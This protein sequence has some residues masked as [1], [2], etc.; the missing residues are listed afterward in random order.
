M[1][2]QYK[3]VVAEDETTLRDSLIKQL[4]EVWPTAKV[5]AACGD[6]ISAITAVKE[7]EPDVLFLDIRM[8][9]K[10]GLEVA[11]SVSDQTF[12]VFTT[13]YDEYAIT[14]FES[15]AID[16]LLKPIETSRLSNTVKRL[17]TRIRDQKPQNIESLIQEL[18]ATLSPD[19]ESIKWVNAR[20]G[21]TVRMISVDDILYF[22]A[23]QKYTKV[24]TRDYE[25]VIRTTL[26]ELSTKLDEDKFWQV[27]RSAIA[28]VN[29]IDSIRK[30]ELGR[31]KLYI[32]ERKESL[33][34]STEFK[35]R[36]K[37]F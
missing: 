22:Q 19:Q 28:A 12:I 5:V 4:A 27:H 29:E 7:H 10:S 1:S 33:P 24:V 17:E 20:S 14:A 8:P 25:A 34:V 13:A 26:K 37:A 18:T 6:G 9:Q 16:Y 3:V 30:D 32:K 21:D 2:N 31:W 36:M 11:K 15:G 35:K 23:D